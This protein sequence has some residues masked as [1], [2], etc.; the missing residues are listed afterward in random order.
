[1]P[2]HGPSADLF[3][4]GP[5]YLESSSILTGVPDWWDVFHA[6]SPES[7]E[8]SIPSVEEAVKVQSRSGIILADFEEWRCAI[9]EP[10][11]MALILFNAYPDSVVM[12]RLIGAFYTT[13]A[14]PAFRVEV[15]LTPGLEAGTLEHKGGCIQSDRGRLWGISACPRRA[16]AFS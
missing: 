6:A 12:T 14:N 16:T 13:P 15:A 5:D 10:L 3:T 8:V 4:E 2:F 7:G 9:V 1:M 11:R